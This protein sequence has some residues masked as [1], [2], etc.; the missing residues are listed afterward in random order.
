MEVHTTKLMDPSQTK[1]MENYDDQEETPEQ[2]KARHDVERD[3]R[4][5][6]RAERK[7][8]LIDITEEETPGVYAK[9]RINHYSR[10][11]SACDSDWNFIWG[12]RG[13]FVEHDAQL[14]PLEARV[15]WSGLMQLGST[16][17]EDY[18]NQIQ[19]YLARYR[20]GN[21]N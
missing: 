6:R 4:Q 10:L 1:E 7:N 13:D 19:K 3:N 14:M 5:G 2:G 15:D 11:Q 18:L 16:T 17:S 9:E 20:N 12:E 8:L 21:Y